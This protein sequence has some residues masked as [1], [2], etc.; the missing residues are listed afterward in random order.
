MTMN[1]KK[2]IPSETILSLFGTKKVLEHRNTTSLNTGLF[3]VDRFVS[4]IDFEF[5]TEKHP[6]EE[7]RP[8]NYVADTESISD[9]DTTMFWD[10]TD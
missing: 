8:P 2:V 9:I 1:K 3:G 5:E 7:A 6:V 4:S 10:V